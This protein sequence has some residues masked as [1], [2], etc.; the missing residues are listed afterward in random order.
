[1]VKGL[2]QILHSFP[3]DIWFIEKLKQMVEHSPYFSLV[4]RIY[5]LSPK[6]VWQRI[7]KSASSQFVRLYEL[8]DRDIDILEVLSWTFS[9]TQINVALWKKECFYLQNSLI[10]D[11][12]TLKLYCPDKLF[13]ILDKCKTRR[14]VVCTSW[15]QGVFCEQFACCVKIEKMPLNISRCVLNCSIV[16]RSIAILVG[17]G[18]PILWGGPVGWLQS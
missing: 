9:N 12:S 5:G 1:M 6:Q 10:C 2:V 18:V 17:R 4:I 15:S 14:V 11:D 7:G 3:E 16:P 8:V 13:C